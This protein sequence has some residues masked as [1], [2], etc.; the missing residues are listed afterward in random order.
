MGVLL[1]FYLRICSS[2]NQQLFINPVFPSPSNNLTDSIHTVESNNESFINRTVIDI[3][4]HS[5]NGY[6]EAVS[7][8]SDII[9]IRDNGN[10]RTRKEAVECSSSPEYHTYTRPVD[11]SWMEY[12]S[13]VY[14]EPTTTIATTTSMIVL[15]GEN[16]FDQNSHEKATNADVFKQ[17]KGYIDIYIHI[18]HKDQSGIHHQESK[19]NNH[20]D[21]Q[22]G[23]QYSSELSKIC[24]G[25]YY[26]NSSSLLMSIPVVDVQYD[27]DEVRMVH[28]NRVLDKMSVFSDIISN[29][30]Q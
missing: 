23:N 9:I 8:T 1:T 15:I 25:R 26:S 22:V 29:V 13:E 4:M 28:I 12:T 20:H 7:S 6:D 5:M 21:N 27:N 30:V 18:N 14:H 24:I 2:I 16:A 10:N 17:L 3:D 11:S 19:N